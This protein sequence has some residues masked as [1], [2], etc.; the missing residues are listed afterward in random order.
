MHF[1]FLLHCG[2]VCNFGYV[3]LLPPDGCSLWD[4]QAVLQKMLDP[5]TILSMVA[6][7][8]LLEEID[9][10]VNFAQMRNVFISDFVGGMQTCHEHL[11]NLYMNYET[12]FRRDRFHG[13]NQLLHL[14]HDQ[15]LLKWEADLNLDAEH[16]AFIF[17]GHTVQAVH[18]GAPMTR[19]VFADLVEL[20]KVDCQGK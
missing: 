19:E 17:G 2:L 10:L 9:V 11:F 16:L 15:I 4:W 20:V 5:Y 12:A 13:L 7:L 6:M 1:L 8:P 3:S 14:S 18:N